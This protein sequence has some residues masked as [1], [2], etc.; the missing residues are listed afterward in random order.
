MEGSS[1][2]SFTIILLVF[3]TFLD[4]LFPSNFFFNF[5]FLF[6]FLFFLLPFLLSFFLLL[7]QMITRTVGALAKVFLKVLRLL[8]RR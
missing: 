6:F 2:C 3:L 8:P 7:R 4:L 1:L 5:F